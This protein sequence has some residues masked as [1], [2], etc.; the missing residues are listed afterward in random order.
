MGDWIVTI[1]AFIAVI[2]VLVFIHEAGHF[3]MAKF[4]KVRVDTFSLGF[5]P[6]LWG[7][8]RGET[9]YR[10]SAI[11]LGGYVK[12]LGE[13]PDEMEDAR[14]LPDALGSKP[15]WQRFLIF[16]AGPGMNILLAI[17]LPA[18]LY[19]FSYSV[20]A[21]LNEPARVG[22][23]AFNSPAEKAGIRAGD[24]IVEYAGIENP[25][26]AKVEDMTKLSPRQSVPIVVER[27]GQRVVTTMRLESHIQSDES[28]GVSGIIPDLP[29]AYTK[30]ME[31]ES[32]KPAA[33]AGLRPGDE[34]V[35]VNDVPVKNFP[36]F[37]AIVGLN[38][39]RELKFT[40]VR[41][42]E[43]FEV[44]ITPFKDEALGRGRIGFQPKPYIEPTVQG[45]LGPIA[46][47]RE[48]VRQ[49][50]YFLW[51]T[52]EALSQIFRG[53][54]T[55]K[56][57]FAGP[58]R[59]AQISGRAAQQGL[60][61]LLGIMAMLSLSLGVFNLLPIPVLD[62]GHVFMLFL[63]AGFGWIGK[64]MTTSLREKLQTVGFIFL[65]LLMGY[66]IYADVAKMIQ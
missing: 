27:Q 31:V 64:E 44:N 1:V 65:I 38:A 58:L 51:I 47:I 15:K 24:L 63:E 23:V 52:G 3:L 28:L 10:V 57:T 14:G 37:Q 4:F 60:E 11:P 13:N 7:F 41:K 66:I 19:M 18:A 36:E 25:I 5:G 49:N 42:G 35:A 56:D 61:P 17:A 6:R 53:E 46:A 26:W 2:G 29:T 16:V 62:G 54:R 50:L 21:Y 59:I 55:V 48:S 20:P 39:G 12:M 34:I 8:K 9:D 40:V 32:G 43:T 33:Q 30:V 22:F 45:R